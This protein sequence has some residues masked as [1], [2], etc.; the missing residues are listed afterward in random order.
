MEYEGRHVTYLE[1]WQWVGRDWWIPGWIFTSQ[2]CLFGEFQSRG[3]CFKW[4]G[5][6]EEGHPR[7]ASDSHLWTYTRCTL[8][9]MHV[10]T[11][12]TATT[13]ICKL[14]CLKLT[15]GNLEA[16]HMK[17]FT[18]IL[19]LKISMAN[20]SCRSMTVFISLMEIKIILSNLPHLGNGAPYMSSL[21]TR[22]STPEG[23]QS[24]WPAWAT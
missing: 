20:Y 21:S 17:L 7:L 5:L 23:L 14:F 16:G 4:K 12:H 6:P 1:A 24:L 19:F 22:E 18:F 15:S 8:T 10:C 13:R 11:V 2:P 3:L 9:R